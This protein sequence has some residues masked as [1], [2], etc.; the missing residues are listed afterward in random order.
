MYAHD[1]CLIKIG[2]SAIGENCYLAASVENAK[3]IIGNGCNF[4]SE[5]AL[6]S[7]ANHTLYIGDDVLTARR[8]IFQCGDGHGMFDVCSGH[9][10]NFQLSN[11]ERMKIVIG[12]HVWFGYGVTVLAPTTIAS[13]VNVAA[14]SVV[15]GE[16]KNNTLLAGIPAVVKRQ[17]H[18]WA[19]SYGIEDMDKACGSLYALPTS[20]LSEE[21]IIISRINNLYNW[22]NQLLKMNDYICVLSIRDIVGAYLQ[23]NEYG[24]LKSIGISKELCGLSWRGYI[25]IS[26][27]GRII[28]EQLSDSENS[29]ETNIIID[30]Y[31][32]YVKSSP[33]HCGNEAIIE[34]NK[35]NYSTNWRG[36]NFVV[37]DKETGQLVDSVCFDTHVRDIICHRRI[38]FV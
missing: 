13:G 2:K 31:K 33:L 25:F 5:N 3:I 10:R 38:L 27:N 6:A 23:Y 4:G 11:A 1:S 12:N 7:N 18:A 32:L 29:I 26:D 9:K 20:T 22:C 30:N 14:N 28:H 16:Y 36:L 19:R 8:A 35:K 37:F 17:N 15:K 34:I 21:K 24:A